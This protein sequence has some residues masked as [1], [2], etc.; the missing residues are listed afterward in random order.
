[1]DPATRCRWV[2]ALMVAP[3]QLVGLYLD[4]VAVLDDG[5]L[6]VS[7]LHTGRIA[8]PHRG[9]GGRSDDWCR[10][11]DRQPGPPRPDPVIERG[12]ELLVRAEVPPCRAVVD[13]IVDGVGVVLQVDPAELELHV[14][15]DALPD[16]TTDGSWVILDV[17]R[18]IA[19]LDHELTE[20]RTQALDELLDAIR[21]QRTGGRFG[22]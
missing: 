7:S 8:E 15:A 4:A 20:Q 6:T 12:R 22:R 18:R 19:A 13:R 1:M 9:G 21:R 16:G 5:S 11:T 3:L 10:P 2:L 14:S 17:P